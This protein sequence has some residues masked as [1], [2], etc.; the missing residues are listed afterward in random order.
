MRV[1]EGRNT[2]GYT[3]RVFTGENEN[4]R[5][6]GEYLKKRIEPENV[7]IREILDVH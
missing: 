2:E 7:V 3:K 1:R 6:L 5:T 4:M